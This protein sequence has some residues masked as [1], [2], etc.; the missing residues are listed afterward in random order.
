MSLHDVESA[1]SVFFLINGPGSCW[2]AD[3]SVSTSRLAL[4][5][6]SGRNKVEFN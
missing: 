6:S 5:L 1:T 2:R 3:G 4:D